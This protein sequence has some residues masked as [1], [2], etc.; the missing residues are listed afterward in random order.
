MGRAVR[1]LKATA[2][3]DAPFATSA[4]SALSLYVDLMASDVQ[5]QNG[6]STANGAI[7]NGTSA[8]VKCEVL[9]SNTQD[10]HY[11]RKFRAW[12]WSAGAYSPPDNHADRQLQEEEQRIMNEVL[13]ELE[14]KLH[15]RL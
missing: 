12:L 14:A 6:A 7:L 11:G 2:P 9:M 5:R 13:D 3:N 8:I 10:T 1:C 15:G 4:D